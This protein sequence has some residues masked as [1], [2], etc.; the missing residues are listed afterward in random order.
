VSPLRR[1]P[2]LPV[3]V[4]WA[5][6]GYLVFGITWII[7]SDGLVEG[8]ALDAV[9]RA[10]LQRIKGLFFV[11]ASASFAVGVILLALARQQRELRRLHEV[12]LHQVNDRLLK[13]F[14]DLPFVGIAFTSPE[15]KHWLRF[16]DRLCEILGYRR[17]ELAQ[18][19]WAEVTHPADLDAD[20][21]EF[22]RVIAGAS[23][24]YSMEK[25]YLRKDGAVVHAFIDVR[26]L[27]RADRSIETFVALVDDITEEKLAR[28]ALEESEA[29]WQRVIEEAPF[30]MIVHDEAG[31]VHALS[32]AWVEL[33]GYDRGEL[34]T[35]EAWLI[36]AYHDEEARQQVRRQIK[37]LYAEPDRVNEGIY[38]ITAADGTRRN[39]M[40][41]SMSLGRVGGGPRMAV[42]MAADV[43]EREKLLEE[44]RSS[45]EIYR[46]M[47]EANP[48]CMLVWD[49]ET[50]MILAANR[51]S[52]EFF[53]W[54]QEALQS[55][56]M[57]E[58]RPPDE[59]EA[60]RARALTLRRNH[61]NRLGVL[62]FWTRDRQTVRLEVSNHSITFADRPAWL[63]M[64][65][66]VEER[67]RA[68]AERDLYVERVERA[69]QGALSVVST[70]VELRD[71]YTAGH[72]RRVGELAAAIAGEMGLPAALQQALRMCGAVHDVGKIAVPAE[73]LS[74]PGRLNA[75]EQQIVQQ[76]A[77]QGFNILRGVDFPWPLAEVARQHHERLDGSGYPRGLQGEQILLEARIIAVADVVE[78]MASHRPYRP[79][80]GIDLALAEIEAGR[81][82]RYDVAAVDACL[83]LFRERGYRLPA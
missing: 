3:W 2:R 65:I 40:F 6:S 42:A 51:A 71:P 63:S 44:I 8:A 80:I 32:R 12:S 66:D 31:T 81:G 57:E 38:T 50:R 20:V 34:P 55:M 61:L 21:A 47:F 39:W 16:N 75:A 46:Q 60:F 17:D 54:P 27:R 73:I 53:G 15:T 7:V 25:R 72:E 49:A 70:M 37:G 10:D 56:H 19:T 24:G 1:V 41:S 67:E 5:I 36:R 83:C 74:K 4:R 9:A 64:G 69:T 33:S 59:V 30:P 13:T 14:F 28:K 18:M 62:R 43:T 23:E 22:D 48:S 45:A 26:C 35:I 11:V 82:S 52:C 78:S 29:R 79:A 58:L 68:R 76:H 77:E